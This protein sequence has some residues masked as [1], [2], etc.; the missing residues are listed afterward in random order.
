[1][2]AQVCILGKGVK[3]RRGS[4]EVKGESEGDKW[5]DLDGLSGCS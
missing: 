1:M 4:N 2:E 5:N 3:W